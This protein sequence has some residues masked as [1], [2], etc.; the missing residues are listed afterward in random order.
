MLLKK[1][2]AKYTI[3]MIA[4]PNSFPKV[5]RKRLR[6]TPEKTLDPAES[7]SREPREAVNDN[8]DEETTGHGNAV[9]DE[10]VWAIGLRRWWR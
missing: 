1:Q 9:R 5:S 8:F 7:R 4:K 3:W 10:P 6:N 2:R